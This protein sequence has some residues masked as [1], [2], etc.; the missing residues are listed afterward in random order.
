[1]VTT[2]DSY[3]VEAPLIAQCEMNPNLSECGPYLAID[4]SD[5]TVENASHLCSAASQVRLL[6]R[7]LRA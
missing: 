1:M 3:D 6:T 4:V 2:T 7:G 5:P